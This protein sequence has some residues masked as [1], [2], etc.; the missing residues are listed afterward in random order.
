[1]HIFFTDDHPRSRL[2]TDRMPRP[3]RR[4][5]VQCWTNLMKRSQNNWN[6]LQ[7]LH[8]PIGNPRRKITEIITKSYYIG[9]PEVMNRKASHKHHI[10]NT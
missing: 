10:T 2:R 8:K 1:M 4:N 7:D 5:L 6:R 9:V 3:K